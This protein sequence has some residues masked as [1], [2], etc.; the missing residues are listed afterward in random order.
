MKAQE[1]LRTSA[2]SLVA[3]AAIALFASAAIA[4][5]PKE[6][7]LYRFKGGAD[8]AN[9]SAGMIADSA[10]NLYGTTSSGGTS[11]LGTVFEVSP[12]GTA[13]TESV[14][15]SFA[16]GSDGA[17]PY[18]K[19]IF[20]KSGNLYGTTYAGGGSANC[21]GT[22]AGCGTVFQLA[23]PATQG[24]PWT[25]TVLYSFTGMRDGANPTAGLIIDSKGDL[26]GTTS[27]GGGVV[28]GTGTCGAIFEL[29]PPAT[30]G[31]PWTEAIIHRFG[32]GSDGI[33]PASSLAFGLRGAIFGTTPSGNNTAQLGIV[34]KLKPP[35]VQGGSWTEGV[36][37]RFAG[38]NDG[39]NPLAGVTVD[40]AGNLYGTTLGGGSQSH[41]VVFEVSRTS[42]GTW[43]EAV[44]YAF[45]GGS[46]GA[47]PTAGLLSDKSGNL[48]GT[49]SSGGQNNNG[50]VFRL[51]P[52]NPWTETTFYDFVGGHDGSQPNGALNVGKGGQLYGTTY[53]GG[54]PGKGTVFRIIH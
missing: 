24:A 10:G 28:C 44:L 25:E 5:T 38:G 23:P 54:G 18:G 16:G 20:D 27:N 21:T 35:A 45:T 37:Y 47:L 26:Y 40:R 4:V 8:G 32:K 31:A 53:L 17:N 1:F 2:R 48:Y 42:S 51:S 33:H 41:G 29:T 14:L 46:D 12:P 11:N 49:T 6:S 15:Y 13:W 34:F 43:T 7:V 22:P 19:L 30:Q 3:L 50:S 39:A 9:P 52:G 36:L